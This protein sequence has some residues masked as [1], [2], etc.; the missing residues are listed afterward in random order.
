MSNIKNFSTQE[1][2]KIENEELEVP[3]FINNKKI[4]KK[5][6]K[7]NIIKKLFNNLMGKKNPKK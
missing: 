2:K 4:K 3:L 1:I 5:T 6:K 7:K